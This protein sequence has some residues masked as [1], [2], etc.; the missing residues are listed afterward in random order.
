MKTITHLILALALL[1][2]VH[3]ATAQTPI[4]A[5]SQNGTLV[6]SGLYPGSY[7]TVEW[8][9]SL[10]G[11]WSADWSSL[12][13]VTVASNGTISV[14]VPMFYRLQGINT[15]FFAADGTVL[16]PGGSFIM[17]DTLDGGTDADGI[18][19][20]LPTNVFVS[21]FYMDTNLV[22]YSQWQT[23]YNW[24]TNH[25]YSFLSP[26]AGAGPNHPVGNIHWQSSVLW[27]NARSEM[28]G[29]APCYYL[30][31]GFTVVMRS[32][33]NGTSTHCY[34]N[35][36]SKGY[37]LPTEAEWEKAARGQLVGARYPWGDTIS[38]SQANY[39]LNIG[40]TT[41]VGSY[42]PN[43]YGLYDMAGNRPQMV[44]DYTGGGEGCRAMACRPRIIQRGYCKIRAVIA[45]WLFFV[46]VARA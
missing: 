2:G 41:P 7:A 45:I 8:A 27:C 3:S 37:R 34:Q 10:A 39:G 31:A 35:L 30:D 17:G 38:P 15:N 9:S 33:T 32:A 18:T 43:F 14:S 23:V 6:G 16:I 13:R 20:A 44:W 40:G 11:P 28:A 26:G 19:N 42:P 21:S 12:T 36:N 25:G 22:S 1:A 5:L 46:A 29:L 4:A 24:A